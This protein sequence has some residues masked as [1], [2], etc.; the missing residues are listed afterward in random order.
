MADAS[1]DEA[2]IWDS[3]L[4]GQVFLGDEAF[5]AKMQAL[6][7]PV[8]RAA[9]DVPKAQRKSPCSLQDCIEQSPGQR[10]QA[11]RRAYRQCGITMTAMAEELGLSVS[12]VSRLIAAAELDVVKGKT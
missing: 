2:P 12:R 10:G 11:L 7:T 3:G 9:V 8:Q 1:P 6:A 5:V 4:R